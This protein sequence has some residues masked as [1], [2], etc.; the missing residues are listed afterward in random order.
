MTLDDINLA[1]ELMRRRQG[2][3]SVIHFSA[4]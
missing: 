4:Q 2:I 1:F 3:H